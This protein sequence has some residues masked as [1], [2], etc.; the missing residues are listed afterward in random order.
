MADELTIVIVTWNTREITRLCLESIHKA[1]PNHLWKVVVVD[2]ASEDHTP[3]MIRN[4]FPWVYLVVN[5]RNMGFGRANNLALRQVKTRYALLLNSDTILPRETV[6]L[7]LRFMDDHPRVGLA[8]GQLIYPDG[9]LQNSIVSFPTLLTELTNKSILQVLFPKKYPGKRHHI[10][11][12]LEVDSVI[13]ASMMIRVDAA[14]SVGFFDEDYFFFLEETDLCFR[15]K[16]QNWKSFFLPGPKIIHYQGSSVRQVKP[17]ARVEYQ[18]SLILFFKKNYGSVPARIIRYYGYF[19]A[20]VGL[21][22]AFPGRVSKTNHHLSWQKY[23]YLLSW[24]HRG[25]PNDMGLSPR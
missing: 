24:Y 8:G 7:F 13:G 23:K 2:N 9:R 11:Q 12:P 21:I 18:R 19:K 1:D 4:E 17:Q 6:P 14:A 16:R 25:C 5:E 15:L 10:D 20:W 22:A 3:E